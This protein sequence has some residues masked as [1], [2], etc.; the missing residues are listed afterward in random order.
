MLAGIDLPKPKDASLRLRAAQLTL[1]RMKVQGHDYLDL[2]QD[3]KRII[4]LCILCL[5]ACYSEPILFQHLNG[6]GHKKMLRTAKLTLRLQNP[7]PF[8]DGMVFFNSTRDEL[9]SLGSLSSQVV[10]ASDSS[11]NVGA[12][13]KYR[14]DV[15]DRS[16]CSTTSDSG[17]LVS[18]ELVGEKNMMRSDQ[19]PDIV[20]PGV[21]W[22]GDVCDIE[23]KY[24]GLAQIG[25][26]FYKEKKCE[27]SN[28]IRRIWCQWLGEKGIDDEDISFLPELDFAVVTLRYAMELSMGWEDETEEIEYQGSK[29]KKRKSFSDPEDTSVSLINHDD[30][31]L[32]M[33]A[34]H[35]KSFSSQPHLSHNST[36]PRVNMTSDE[37]VLTGSSSNRALRKEIRKRQRVAVRRMCEVCKHKMQPGKD[38][39]ALLNLKTGK[40]AC[41]SRNMNGAFHVF[42]VSC[43]LHWILLCEYE[44]LTSPVE[45]P[46]WK[47]LA[48]KRKTK[49]KSQE[50]AMVERSDIHIHSVVCPACQ[51]TGKNILGELEN[52]PI[53]PSQMF[54]YMI[55]T[56]DGRRAWMKDPEILQN[57]SIGLH[58]PPEESEEIVE[59]LSAT[60]SCSYHISHWKLE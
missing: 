29:K 39:A 22:K 10:E 50:M 40:L 54:K 15:T 12:L 47:R 35:D 27:E 13:V 20:V 11:K 55:R 46:K 34:R 18:Y 49:K 44:T 30:P 24:L 37:L 14:G 38:V 16:D 1:R 4:Y 45:T 52:N 5:K 17:D 42:H 53:P 36:L 8:N 26:R 9:R 41:S 60:L 48:K 25:A 23:L 21:L 7:W 57:C 19:D 43:L 6:N 59:E 58:Y 2:R 33:T 31:S 3:G 28:K 32:E 56:F 51:G